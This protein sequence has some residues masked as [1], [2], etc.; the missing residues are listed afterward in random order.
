M[1]RMSPRQRL[2]DVSSG[3]KISIGIMVNGSAYWR[4][5]RKAWGLF[6]Q[7]LGRLFRE[8]LPRLNRNHCERKLEL[9][10]QA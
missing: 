2:R 4:Q 1:L 5:D 10:E 6:S 8:E 3:G 7:P 9:I